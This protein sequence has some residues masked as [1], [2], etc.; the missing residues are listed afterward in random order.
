MTFKAIEYF[1]LMKLS[2][3]G[4]IS[5]LIIYSILSLLSTELDKADIQIYFDILPEF[6]SL[7][8]PPVLLCLL[9]LNLIYKK[10][11]KNR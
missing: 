11:L 4:K 5:I 10:I 2:D 3:V 6:H 7:N 1:V 9:L 8:P